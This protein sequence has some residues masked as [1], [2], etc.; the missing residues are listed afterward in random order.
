MSLDVA[1]LLPKKALSVTK[2]YKPVGA[3]SVT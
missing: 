2:D 3:L 1:G